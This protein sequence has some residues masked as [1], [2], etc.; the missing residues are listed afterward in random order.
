MAPEYYQL[1]LWLSGFFWSL[2][3]AMFVINYASILSKP[4]IDGRPG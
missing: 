3:F 4:R 1:W 2:A